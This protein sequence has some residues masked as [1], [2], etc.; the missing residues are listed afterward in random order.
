LY[1][2]P[3]VGMFSAEIAP[4]AALAAMIAVYL[5]DLPDVVQIAPPILAVMSRSGRNQARLAPLERI[6]T[7]PATEAVGVRS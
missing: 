5:A 2:A 1:V 7:L 3:Q 4:E 6:W